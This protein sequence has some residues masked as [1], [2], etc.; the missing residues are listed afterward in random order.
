MDSQSEEVIKAR[1]EDVCGELNLDERSKDNAWKAYLGINN[2]YVLEVGMIKSKIKIEKE[3]DLRLCLPGHRY[4]FL[5][6]RD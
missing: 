5:H 2:D 4:S 1:F 6:V 3:L